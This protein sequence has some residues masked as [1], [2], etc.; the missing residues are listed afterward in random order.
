LIAHRQCC[1][2][3]TLAAA[4]SLAACA[5]PG[6]DRVAEQLYAMGTT[7][8]VV[9]DGA[10]P[11]AAQA[12]MREIEALL[13]AFERD[14]Y[15]WG[16]GELAELNRALAAGRRRQVSPELAALLVEAASLSATSEGY[17][18]P[19]VGKLVELWG[20]QDG[21]ALPSKAPPDA[22]IAGLMA[23]PHGIATLT[24]TGRDIGSGTKNLL[25]DLGGIA[26]GRAVDRI[27]D[28]LAAHG[29]ANAM[30]NAG[31]DLRVLGKPGDRHWRVGIQAPRGSGII[32]AVELESGEAAFTS[33]DYERYFD[34]DGQRLHHLLDPKTGR[35][36]Q[37]TQALTVIARD[38]TTA[39]AAATA[40]FVAGPD[41]WRRIARALGIDSVLRVDASGRIEATPAMRDR[42][43]IS[44][45]AASD[46]IVADL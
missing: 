8:D 38:G 31:G 19:G 35:P 5:D 45:G 25:L 16:D 14:Y 34:L 23:A 18:D 4:A 3:V 28:L 7:V 42:L 10:E 12:A 24:I 17:F 29:I 11:A 39:D 15:A 32:G 1:I 13:R 6:D 33:G 43:Q 27:V 37:H 30:V 21:S 46:I 20:F 22:A 2:T 9:I 41:N 40:L 26:K 44:A 36:A